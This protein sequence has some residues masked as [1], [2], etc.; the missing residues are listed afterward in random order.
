MITHQMIPGQQTVFTSMAAAVPGTPQQYMVTTP[1]PVNVSIA[2]ASFNS[3]IA[4]NMPQGP[5]Y[6]K[7]K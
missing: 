5:R 3:V 4:A 2:P 7:G 6:R 1:T